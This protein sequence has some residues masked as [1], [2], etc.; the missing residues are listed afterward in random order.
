MTN[1]YAQEISFQALEMDIKEEGNLIIAFNSET[2]IPS[3][4]LKI[5]SDKVQYNKKTDIIIFTKNVVIN[6]LEN[7]VKINSNR[8]IYEKKKN[9]IF[10]KGR[11]KFNI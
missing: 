8:V 3:E 9:L 2:D 10:S 11:T 1:V 6:D 7:D 4:N 5:Y